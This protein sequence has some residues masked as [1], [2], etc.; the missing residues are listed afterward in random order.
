MDWAGLGCMVE[1]PHALIFKVTENSQ[2]SNN[3]NME[4]DDQLDE[5]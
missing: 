4:F 1:I 2:E 3:C 5:V